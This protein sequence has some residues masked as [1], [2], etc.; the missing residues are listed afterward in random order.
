MPRQGA[1]LVVLGTGCIM[2]RC[3]SSEAKQRKGYHLCRTQNW[4]T[5]KYR[6]L[7]GGHVEIWPWWVYERGTCLYIMICLWQKSAG[8]DREV[9]ASNVPKFVAET[10]RKLKSRVAGQEKR[11]SLLNLRG[12]S[13]TLTWRLAATEMHDLPSANTAAALYYLLPKSI[14][15]TFAFPNWHRALLWYI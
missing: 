15:T 14:D 7:F 2:R 11:K 1:S 10:R 9:R 12:H 3:Q 4:G 13:C 8:T 5:K 6:D